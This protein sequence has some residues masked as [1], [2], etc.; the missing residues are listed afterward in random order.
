MTKKNEEHDKEVS[1][2]GF[3]QALCLG[4][5]GSTFAL[6]A[7]R[8]YNAGECFGKS[9]CRICTRKTNCDLPLAVTFRDTQQALKKEHQ[10]KNRSH[11]TDPKLLKLL[12]DQQD[13]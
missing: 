1:R 9:T 5:M 10:L 12:E 2:R 6:L 8:A 11:I 7:S 4:G 13:G 3:F